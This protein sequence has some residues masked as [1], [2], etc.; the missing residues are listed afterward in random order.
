M[1][2]LLAVAQVGNGKGDMRL[3]LEACSQAL[4]QLTQEAKEA[5]EKAAAEKA[6]AAAAAAEAPAG[7]AAGKAEEGAPAGAK[8]GAAAARLVG[9]RHMGAALNSLTGGIGAGSRYVQLIRNLTPPQKLIMCAVAKLLGESAR[10][11]K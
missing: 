8:A 4:S 1:C 5:A 9:M 11:S 7:A 6:A 10:A 2:S 3:A